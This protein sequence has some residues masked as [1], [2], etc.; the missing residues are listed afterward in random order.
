MAAV[1]FAY[2]LVTAL[3]GELPA[4]E[5]GKERRT[6][7][8]GYIYASDGKTVLAVLRGS[9]SRVIVR[10]EEIAPVMKQAIV[11]VEDR[12]FWEHSGVDVRGM[13][14]AFWNDIRNKQV[15][16]GGSTITQQFVKNQYTDRG[17]TVSRKLKEATLAW[18]LEQRWSK[19][20]ILTAYLNTIYFGNAAYGV[21]MASRVYFGKHAK[22]LTL[23][24]A[25]LLAGLPAN[26]GAYDPAITPHAARARRTTVL[27]LMLAQ[28]LISWKAY[29]RA[30]ETPLPRPRSIGLPASRGRVQYFAEYV[31]QQLIPYYG[32]GTVF[33]GGL[34][35][36]TSIDLELQRLARESIDRWLTDPK[37]PTAALVA[38]R[39]ARRPGRRHGRREE[40]PEEPVQPRRAGRAPVGIRLQAVRPRDRARRGDLAADRVRLETDRDQPRRQ[41]LVGRELR[42]SRPGADRPR[43]GDGSLRQHRVRAADR[44]GRPRERC[45]RWPAGWASRARSTTTSPSGSGS[46]P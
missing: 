42:G 4:L 14:R 13:A 32:S 40:L 10:S 5:P 45:R 11:A 17:R 38:V 6:E 44:P 2:G 12:R 33:G 25:A 8:L 24:E 9:E 20:R 23:P 3:A 15:V 29:Q 22:D 41:A 19:E 21:E 35:I 7:R 18:Q 1:S 28:G 31:K 37:G 30:N 36:Y 46:K 26:P 43:R 16:E 34:K 27:R 39:P